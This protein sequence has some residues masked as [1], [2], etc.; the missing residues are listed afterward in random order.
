MVA[1]GLPAV[2]FKLS[3]STTAEFPVVIE[4]NPTDLGLVVN[5]RINQTT[6]KSMNVVDT[7]NFPFSHFN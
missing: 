3:V 4:G 7:A 1:I 2:W 6:L 5:I